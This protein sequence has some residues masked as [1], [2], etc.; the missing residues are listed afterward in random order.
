VIKELPA[1]GGHPC[2]LQSAPFGQNEERLCHLDVGESRVRDADHL[3]RPKPKPAEGRGGG[4]R[5]KCRAI[6]SV[7]VGTSDWAQCRRRNSYLPLRI[8]S[9]S[10]KTITRNP[11]ESCALG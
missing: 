2:V 7:G 6:H 3:P 11:V 9:P 8:P 10:Q 4:S 1:K 5:L